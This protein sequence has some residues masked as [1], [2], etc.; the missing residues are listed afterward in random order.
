VVQSGNDL[1]SKQFN[2]VVAHEHTFLSSSIPQK[3]EAAINDFHRLSFQILSRT[4][5]FLV[6]WFEHLLTK[7]E[8]FNDQ[9]QAKNLIEGGKRHIASEDYEK[10]AEV[11]SRLHAL[12]P[13]KETD[14][15]EMR[16]FTGIS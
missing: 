11:N 15:K 10:L 9:L 16:Y 2:E 7:R 6:G 14:S 8:S 1:E 4:P 13:Q 3:I 5:D 12:L